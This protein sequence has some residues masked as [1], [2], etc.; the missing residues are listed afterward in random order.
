MDGEWKNPAVTWGF[1]VGGMGIQ[2]EVPICLQA[3]KGAGRGMATLGNWC[4]QKLALRQQPRR[5]RSLP[6]NRSYRNIY[7]FTE[8]D[9]VTLC[10]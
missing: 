7:F 3:R 4:P 6:I 8:Y 1:F 2:I 10:L 5:A 9:G